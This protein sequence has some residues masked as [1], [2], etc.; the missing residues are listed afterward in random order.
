MRKVSLL[1]SSFDLINAFWKFRFK[2]IECSW[3]LLVIVIVV[4]FDD[5]SVYTKMELDDEE[6]LRG[7][8]VLWTHQLYTK[9]SKYKFWLPEMTHDVMW[10]QGFIVDPIKI[11]AVTRLP[12]LTT[13]TESRSF[14]GYYRR[15]AHEFSRISAAFTQGTKKGKPFRLVASMQTEFPRN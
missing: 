1:I 6:Y 10:C 7:V 11:D 15:F 12:K 8:M 3:N 13:V 4:V 5:M 2:Q 14:H 9:F